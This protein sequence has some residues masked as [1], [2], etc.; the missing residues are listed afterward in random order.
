MCE[1][2]LLLI[3]VRKLEHATLIFSSYNITD[4]FV[5]QSTISENYSMF[6]INLIIPV[7]VTIILYGGKTNTFVPTESSE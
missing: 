6:V 2:S 5:Q 4:H 7:L 1:L 3:V